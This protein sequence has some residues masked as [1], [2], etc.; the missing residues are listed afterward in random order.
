MSKPKRP[1]PPEDPKE[2]SPAAGNEGAFIYRPW[3]RH[4]KTGEKLWAKNYGLKAWAIPVSELTQE[5][6][7]L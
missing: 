2:P 5:N 6:K 1:Q 4:P 3:R 7:D